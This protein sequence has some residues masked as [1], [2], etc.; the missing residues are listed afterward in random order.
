VAS[1]VKSRVS[2]ELIKIL[3]DGEWYNTRYLALVAGKYIPPER[4]SRT[5][6]RG[7]GCTVETG[8]Y[9][10][11]NRTLRGF[12]KQERVETRRNGRLAE[13]RLS[14]IQWAAQMLKWA[15]EPVPLSV[16]T[17]LTTARM[18]TIS[19]SPAYYNVLSEVKQAYEKA[20]GKS[21]SWDAF[22]IGLIGSSLAG[23]SIRKGGKGEHR[24]YRRKA[25]G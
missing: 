18:Q 1:R 20:T 2:L 13:W 3:S 8:R 10:I 25:S 7:R 11:V 9:D 6:R 24:D 14:N 4:A 21:L 22:L 23:K 15:G 17:L 19:L 12:L 5:L 16:F